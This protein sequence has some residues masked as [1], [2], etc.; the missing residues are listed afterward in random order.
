M[1]LFQQSLRLHSFFFIKFFDVYLFLRE[2]QS[3]SRGGAERERETQNPKQAP[4]SE[5][6]ARPRMWAQRARD[7][8]A[9]SA[10]LLSC[11]QSREHSAWS[12]TPR[13]DRQGCSPLWPPWLPWPAPLVNAWNE[14]GEGFPEATRSTLQRWEKRR[15][16]WFGAVANFFGFLR[17]GTRTVWA[18][19]IF[20][21]T[22][23]RR[24]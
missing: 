16:P 22:E 7:A 15:L 9:F 20:S 6:P 12:R 18:S 13:A 19:G 24:W 17:L 2:R 23:S 14:P 11:P 3:V 10:A 1:L 8:L 4:G 21:F 5:L